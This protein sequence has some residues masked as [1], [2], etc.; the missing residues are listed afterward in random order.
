MRNQLIVY[1]MDV[2]SPTPKMPISSMRTQMT[3][4]VRWTAMAAT[5]TYNI[6]VLTPMASKY[7]RVH[8]NCMLKNSPGKHITR[9]SQATAADSGGWPISR[10]SCSEYTIISV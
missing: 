6:G 2:E 9:Y 10:K 5:R 7:L 4:L 1:V 3:R 8:S